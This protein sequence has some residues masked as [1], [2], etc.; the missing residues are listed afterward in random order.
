MQFGCG[1]WKRCTL[2]RP[3]FSLILYEPRPVRWPR[4]RWT[5]CARCS[6]RTK[7]TLAQSRTRSSNK[8]FIL[9]SCNHDGARTIFFALIFT[10]L[11]LFMT[12]GQSVER[13]RTTD[14][15]GRDFA[16][17]H[18]LWEQMA[19][20]RRKSSTRTAYVLQLKHGRIMI[21]RRNIC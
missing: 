11:A 20:E 21:T 3:C 12:P 8:P 13:R 16:P 5:T 7:K 18:S 19:L 10:S 14:N 2:G 15:M 1:S 17:S 4:C 9:S 6:L